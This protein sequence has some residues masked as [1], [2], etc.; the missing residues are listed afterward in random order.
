MPEQAIM[1]LGKKDF[2]YLTWGPNAEL[3]IE[4]TKEKFRANGF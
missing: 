3:F 2:E 4:K 1:Q